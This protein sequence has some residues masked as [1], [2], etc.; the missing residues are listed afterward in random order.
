MSTHTELSIIF[1]KVTC[2]DVNAGYSGK[3][4]P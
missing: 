4:K 3:G 1:P 2:S